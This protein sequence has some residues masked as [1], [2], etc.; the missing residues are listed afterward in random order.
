MSSRSSSTPDRRRRRALPLARKHGPGRGL[1]SVVDEAG[2]G[3]LAGPVFAAAVILDPRKPVEGLND[4]KQLSEAARERL[5]EAICGQALCMSIAQAS[6]DEIDRMNILQAT[7]LAMQR[8]VQGLRLPPALVL[9][10]GNRCPRLPM[11][12]EAVVKGDARV[13]EVA[14]ASI[15]AKVARDRCCETLEARWPG[16]GFAR[17]KGYPTAEHLQQLKALGPCA[18]H[19]RSYAP[20]RA[21]LEPPLLMAGAALGSETAGRAPEGVQ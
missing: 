8:A 16:Y 11:A 15:L 1:L 14:A 18:D 19:R 21:L 17:H 9:V 13:A 4:S 3:P 2:R 5:Y 12:A 10:D 20:V 7:F 6:V